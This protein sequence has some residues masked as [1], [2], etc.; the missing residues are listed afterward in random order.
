MKVGHG[1]GW[2]GSILG[3][4][5]VVSDAAHACTPDGGHGGFKN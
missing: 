3:I 5:G 4:C 1:V 2:L